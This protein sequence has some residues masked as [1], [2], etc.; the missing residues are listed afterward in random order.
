MS[1][2][3]V[4]AMLEIDG[5]T[6]ALIAAGHAIE[7]E[8][9]TPEGLLLRIVAPTE[10]GIVL[11]QLWRS[12]EDRQRNADDPRHREVLTDSGML[13]AAKGMHARAFDDATLQVF[14]DA[15]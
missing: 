13:A 7:A 9:G 3:P 1:A 15:G 6:D 2:R 8:L 5:D 4:L 12:Q 10:K 11:L 14:T